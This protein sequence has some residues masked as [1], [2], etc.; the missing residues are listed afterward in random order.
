MASPGPNILFRD[1]LSSVQKAV[2]ELIKKGINKIIVLSHTGFA[3]EKEICRTVR[4]VDI[5]VGGYT[6]TFLYTGDPPSTE[7]P[8]DLYP[9]ETKNVDDATTPCLVVQAYAY[10]KYVGHLRV[11]FDNAGVLKNWTGNPILV[12]NSFPE[13]S[14]MVTLLKPFRERVEN[15]SKRHVAQTAVYL[16]GSR[17]R[18]RLQEC[19][20]A[21]IVT[22]AAV[23]S[24]VKRK[25][26]RND[27]DTSSWTDAAVAFWNSGGVRDFRAP[28]GKNLT[29]GNLRSFSPFENT[30]EKLKMLGTAL[31][32]ALERGVEDYD[33]TKKWGWF[34]Q[35][36][37]LIVVYNLSKPPNE[38]VH[39]VMVRCAKCKVPKYEPLDPEA[40]YDVVVNSYLAGGGDKYYVFKDGRISTD[41][42][43]V[44]EVDMLQEYLQD[45]EPI[46]TGEEMRIQF[47]GDPKD[48]QTTVSTEATTSGSEMPETKRMKWWG[49]TI[50]I[51]LYAC[52]F[53]GR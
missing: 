11:S 50:L 3:M 5:V 16:D 23:Y 30:I 53:Y 33:G 37:G 14:T 48:Y 22:D 6:N 24:Y 1:E 20:L 43:Q 42:S 15:Y 40:E 51:T 19:N 7:V 4:G 45:F 13:D 36:S 18:C 12:N 49:I 10:G 21:N 17:S 29:F 47:I 35:V 25:L 46:M 8:Q 26:D 39:E 31:L 52:D 28:P 9:Y 32:K 27:S 44:L 41:F 2:D 34:P 38:R